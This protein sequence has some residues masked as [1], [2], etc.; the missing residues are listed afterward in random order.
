MTA[1]Q[2]AEIE[3]GLS[4]AKKLSSEF[5]DTIHTALNEELDVRKAQAART[6]RDKNDYYISSMEEIVKI[7]GYEVKYDGNNAK[8]ERLERR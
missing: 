6:L 2:K 7:L 3:K 5:N 1:T 4:T 8:L